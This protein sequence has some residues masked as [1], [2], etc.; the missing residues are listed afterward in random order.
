MLKTIKEFFENKYFLLYLIFG[1]IPLFFINTEHDIPILY[2]FKFLLIPIIVISYYYTYTRIN[3]RDSL[4]RTTFIIMP[5]LAALIITFF[6]IGYIAAI[7]TIHHTM[8]EYNGKILLKQKIRGRYSTTYHV[9]IF[10]SSLNDQKEFDISSEEYSHLKE[11][12]LYRSEWK[13]G[14]L[15]IPY[16][17]CW[18]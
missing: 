4:S 18:E 17:M 5:L 11:G 16:K 10:D 6:S 12:D 3:W 1:I 8:I 9:I 7:N 2:A 14:L 15:G 13:I